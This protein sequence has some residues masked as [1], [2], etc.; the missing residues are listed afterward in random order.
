MPLREEF[1]SYGNILFKHRSS[2]P[3]IFLV[4]ALI[5][6][7]YYQYFNFPRYSPFTR[8]QYEIIALLVSVIGQI[9]RAYTVGYT[10]DG[11]SGRNT[12]TQVASEVNQTGIYSI[13][14]HP[15]YIGNYFMWLG[16]AMLTENFWFAMAFTFLYWVYYERIMFAEEEFLREKFGKIYTTWAVKTPAFFPSFKNLKKPSLPFSWKKVIKKEKNGIVGIFVIFYLFEIVGK[17]AKNLSININTSTW[18]YPAIASILI[19]FFLRYLKYNSS[20]FKE[21]GR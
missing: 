21:D 6:H 16:V 10:P 4:I 5:A 13:V 1:Q 20:F 19:Y 9:I 3:I 2:L 8:F 18:F 12:A 15:L 11:T 17:V 14:R 7:A